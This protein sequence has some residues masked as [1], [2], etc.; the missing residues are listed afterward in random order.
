MH[1]GYFNPDFIITRKGMYKC[2]GFYN[3]TFNI[4]CK[5]MGGGGI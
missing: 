3:A 4:K 5:L 2:T 1:N